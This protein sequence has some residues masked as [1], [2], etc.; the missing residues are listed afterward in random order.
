MDW[1]LTAAAVLF[2][3]AYAT[4][5]ID[6][7]L[8]AWLVSTCRL[9]TWATWALFALD[10][11]IR[12]R[13]DRNRASFVRRNVLDLLV[14]A[15]P[16]LRP[17]RLL[18]LVVLLRVLNRKASTGL[19][20][21]VAA[22]V[23]GGSALLAFVGALA[24]LDAE[25]KS[26]EANITTFA[27]AIWW[28]VTTMTTV[29]YGDRFPVTPAGRLSAVGLMLAGIALLG[30][31]TA[32]FA[33]WLIERVTEDTEATTEL[34]EEIAALRQ[35]IADLTVLVRQQSGVHEVHGFH[36]AQGVDSGREA[37]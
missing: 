10:Y 29:G 36:E 2:L 26:P 24:V 22:Y 25:R 9:M 35:Q 33:S 27:D 31:V 18:R 11:F 1:P 20:G 3:A 17:L 28:A 14:I 4:P 13:A 37:V 16:L 30:V 7:D 23:V 6:P 12:L 8:P 5:I 15:L 32:T 21:R 19:R 34:T